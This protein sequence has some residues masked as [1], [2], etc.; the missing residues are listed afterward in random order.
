MHR[1]F[2]VFGLNKLNISPMIK[3]IAK[4]KFNVN[5]L[6]ILRNTP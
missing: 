5:D 4:I 6:E 3:M 2:K 1:A